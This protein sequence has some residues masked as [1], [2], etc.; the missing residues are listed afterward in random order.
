[1]MLRVLVLAGVLNL[2]LALALA[3]P[4]LAAALFQ[5]LAAFVLI[6]RDGRDGGGQAR[7][8]RPQNPFLLSEVLRFG[9]M[10]AS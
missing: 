9:A 6:G 3:V 10:L 1:M 4:L 2:A 8:P 5:A 7:G